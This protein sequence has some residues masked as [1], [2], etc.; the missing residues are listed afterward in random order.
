MVGSR[1]SS[2]AYDE[3][4]DAEALGAAVEAV[5]VTDALDLARHGRQGMH[6]AT[7]T[8]RSTRQYGSIG[9]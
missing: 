2:F 7:A 5:L 6:P 1:L 9:G 3:A 8:G 4:E